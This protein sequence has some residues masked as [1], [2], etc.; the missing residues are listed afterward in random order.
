MNE[1]ARLDEFDRE[2]WRVVSRLFRPDW[3]EEDFNREW[4]DFQ[5]LKTAELERRAAGGL[6]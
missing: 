2:E 5:K 1:T 3:T 4:D 6:Q